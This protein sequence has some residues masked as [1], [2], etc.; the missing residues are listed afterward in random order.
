MPQERRNGRQVPAQPNAFTRGVAIGK[1]SRL[2]WRW[3]LLLQHCPG[4]CGHLKQ[5][6]SGPWVEQTRRVLQQVAVAPRSGGRTLRSPSSSSSNSLHD[7]LDGERGTTATVSRSR[8]FVP[9]PMLGAQCGL[10]RGDGEGGGGVLTFR[11]SRRF[12]I[13]RSREQ[14][15]AEGMRVQ[16]RARAAP[17]R[18]GEMGS[19]ASLLRGRITE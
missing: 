14:Q 10:Q 19:E 18:G 6:G 4:G 8:A 1:V 5:R 16:R 2:L 7:T 13:G 9:L 11:F 15:V 12:G 3:R 17:G